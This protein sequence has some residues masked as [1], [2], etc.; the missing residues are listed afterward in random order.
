[1]VKQNADK[2]HIYWTFKQQKNTSTHSHTMWQYQSSIDVVIRNH[3]WD[4]AQK[5]CI[6]K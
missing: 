2:T 4:I 5:W 1:M 6:E 3:V